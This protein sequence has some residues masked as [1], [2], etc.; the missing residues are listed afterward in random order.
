MFL[1]LGIVLALA[2]IWSVYWL[3]ALG[4][5]KERLSEQRMI[6]ADRGVNLSC[7]QEGWGGYPFHLEYT[8][9]SPAAI[10]EGEGELRSTNL[11]LV[12]LAYAPWQVVALVDGP[13][14]V[15]LQGTPPIEVNHERI[16]AAVTFKS[17]TKPSVSLE[18]PVLS[19]PGLGRLKELVLYTRPLGT[20][21]VE[22]ALR[23][24]NLEYQ[25]P[26]HPPFTLDIGSLRGT[27]QLDRTITVQE[28]DLQQGTLRYWGAGTLSLDSEHRISGKIDTETND[29]SSLLAFL[30]PHLNLSGAQI[31]NLKTMLGL[32]GNA[33]KAPLIARDG[34]L[35]LGPLKIAELEPIY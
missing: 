14:T 9:R 31:A 28:F 32:L 29:I 16:L 6:M 30:A 4:I 18:L 20:K 33:A 5:A 1:P 35:Y 21:D 12:A 26:G 13:T 3:I 10:V 19:V 17:G 8:C 27:I 23:V 22:L 15:S 7:T 34:I 2:V 25:S 24:T 11:L